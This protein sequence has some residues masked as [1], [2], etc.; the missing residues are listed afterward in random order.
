MDYIAIKQ[1]MN[2]EAKQK[3]REKDFWKLMEYK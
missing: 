1:I 2:G 3:R